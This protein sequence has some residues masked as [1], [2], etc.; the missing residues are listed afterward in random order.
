MHIVIIVFYILC[1]NLLLISYV[2]AL[3]I[4]EALFI[5]LL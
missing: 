2:Y 4:L 5:Y 1:I 3:R